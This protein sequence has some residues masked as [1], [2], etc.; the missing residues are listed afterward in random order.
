[1]PLIYYYIIFKLMQSYP[2]IITTLYLYFY[3]FFT[4][5]A[6]R[7]ITNFYK[8]I[9]I[10]F[11]LVWQ[12]SSTSRW[13]KT[14]RSSY[15]YSP[16]SNLQKISPKKKIYLESKNTFFKILD[17]KKKI[18]SIKLGITFWAKTTFLGPNKWLRMV[19]FLQPYLPYKVY[20]THK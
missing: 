14:K 10:I 18:F 5:C 11:H 2:Y 16:H 15:S 8:N 19:P 20:Y 6:T 7:F 9:Y 12:F 1:L 4:I 13:D 3:L 17:P